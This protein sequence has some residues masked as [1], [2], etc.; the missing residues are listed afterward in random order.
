MTLMVYALPM[1]LKVV[2]VRALRRRCAHVGALVLTY[3]NG[4]D[5]TLSDAL[6]E[7]LERAGA[8]ATFFLLGARA[9]R[10]PE[11]MDRLVAAEH[12]VACLLFEIASD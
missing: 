9:E 11:R 6:L 3:E 2:Q 5:R 1:A 8:R 7:T 10:D 12:E 4:P